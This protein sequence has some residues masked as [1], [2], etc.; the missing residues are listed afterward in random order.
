MPTKQSDDHGL[1]PAS[2]T[3][4]GRDLEREDLRRG[5]G[6]DLS[7]TPQGH[8][9]LGLSDEARESEDD[10]RRGPGVDPANA[11]AEDGG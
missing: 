4:T 3:R 10:P 6:M 1:P 9:P 8:D 7:P 2:V 11:G 5:G